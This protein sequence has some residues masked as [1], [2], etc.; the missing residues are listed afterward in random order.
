MGTNVDARDEL[1]GKSCENV[2]STNWRTNWENDKSLISE[3]WKLISSPLFPTLGIDW[4]R[5]AFSVLIYI[6]LVLKG[7]ST[8]GWT[9]VKP[10]FGADFK[11]WLPR[12]QKFFFEILPQTHCWQIAFK[13]RVNFQRVADPFT[14]QFEYLNS[15]HIKKIIPPIYLRN[16]F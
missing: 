3:S 1:M 16:V 9:S 12:V 14:K 6:F 7:K 15:W 4:S 10:Y 13:M 8:N 11:C 2:N 5:S